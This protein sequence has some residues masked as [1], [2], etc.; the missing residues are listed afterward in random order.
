ME[1]RAIQLPGADGLRLH[2]LEWSRE[3]TL[4]LLL[5]GFGNSSRVWDD[6]APALAPHYRVIALDQ[7]GHGDSERDPEQRY[8]PASMARD[9]EAVLA[10]LEASRVVLVGHSMGGRVSMEFA[11][12]HPEMLAGLV[13]V[14]IGPESDPRGIL[15]ISMEVQEQP[16][17]FES[18]A[19]YRRVL[20]RQYPETAPEVLSR[21]AEHW[22]RQRPDGRFELKL[23][24]AF[25]LRRGA[26]PLAE[27]LDAEKLDAQRVWDILRKVP[28]PAL[29]VRGAA[30][31]ILSPDTA[32]RMADEALPDAR[33]AVIP[34]AA[35][36]VMLDNPE[37][38]RRELCRF[39]LGED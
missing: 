21:M 35:H 15:R 25:N 7:R 34:R 19:D 24:P 5:H 27:R 29:V 1:P 3:G 14:D 11:G 36:S 32:D 9:V 33:L 12:L 8:D 13:L 28:C 38:F 10:A 26:Q 23:D 31:D 4:L 22:T 2:A 37:G 18:V 30:S 17:S 20:T 6:C 16:A 39:A